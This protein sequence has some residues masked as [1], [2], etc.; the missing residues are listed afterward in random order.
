MTVLPRFLQTSVFL[1][2]SL[3]VGFDGTLN[4]RIEHQYTTPILDI[5]FCYQ[6]VWF[7]KK[8]VI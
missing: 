3:Y 8:A 4:F 6:V 1:L 5:I 7:F 2:L